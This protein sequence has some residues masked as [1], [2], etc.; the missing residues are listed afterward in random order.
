MEDNLEIY[1]TPRAKETLISVYH[2]IFQKFGTKA[3]DKFV[4]KAEKTIALLSNQPLCLRRPLQWIKAYALGWSPNNARF[5]IALLKLRF[6]CCSFGIIVSNQPSK[7]Y[8][9]VSMIE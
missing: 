9:P 5:F 1:Y 7:P 2:F 4:L 6:I 3:A 8:F